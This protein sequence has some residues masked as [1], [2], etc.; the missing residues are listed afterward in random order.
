VPTQITTSIREL[1]ISTAGVFD[2]VGTI[3]AA[4]REFEN[5]SLQRAAQLGDAFG[6]DDRIKGVLDTRVDALFGLPLEL[7]PRGDARKSKS[8]VGAFEENFKAWFPDAELKKFLRWGVLLRVAFGRLEWQRGPRS[9]EPRFRCWEP[10]YC[11]WDQERRAWLTLTEDGEREI[12]PGRDGWIVY[13]PDGLYRGWMQGL[14]RSLALLYV[15]RKWAW[16]DWA[17]YSEVHGLP[18][19]VGIVPAAAPEEE[20]EAFARSIRTIGGESVFRVAKDDQGNGFDLKLVEAAAQS[21]EGFQ[22]LLEKSDECIA[23]D[24]LGQNLTTSMKSGGSYAAANVHDRI[25]LDR[26][27]GDAQSVGPCLREQAAKPIAEALHGDAELAP[28]L[29]WSTKAPEDRAATAKTLNDLGDA[30][31]KL[32]KAGLNVDVVK[33]A[34]Q[35]RVPL[36]EGKPTVEP[37]PDDEPE[38]VDEGHDEPADEEDEASDA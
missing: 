30:L 26:L 20:K 8:V 16:R 32:K 22:R 13:A 27:E 7:K 10:H 12:T 5:G 37:E 35:F 38:R 23:V 31:T 19:R 6:E 28:G 15:I 18:M 25:R 1:P 11:R 9:W 29:G 36:V 4:L 34:E 24:V 14:V 17:R 3:R 21:Y 33:V 2:S